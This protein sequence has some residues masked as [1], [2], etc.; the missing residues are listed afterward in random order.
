MYK[1]LKQVGKNH[2]RKL[3]PHPHFKNN[4]QVCFP[5]QSHLHLM[6]L[7]EDLI[8]VS[9]MALNGIERGGDRPLKEP[10]RSISEVLKHALDLLPLEEAEFIDK[11]T[12]ILNQQETKD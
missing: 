12:E 1:R 4:Q 3:T 10:E 7:I 5:A 6:F 11:S 8:K 9:V 2:L